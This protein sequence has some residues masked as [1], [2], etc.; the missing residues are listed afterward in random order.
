MNLWLWI[1][2]SSWRRLL[3][4]CFLPSRLIPNLAAGIILA[5]VVIG[6]LWYQTKID[7]GFIELTKKHISILILLIPLAVVL[8]SPLPFRGFGGLIRTVS[9]FVTLLVLMVT[10]FMDKQ[11]ACYVAFYRVIGVAINFMLFMIGL[12]SKNI[13]VTKTSFTMFMCCVLVNVILGIIGYSK[14]DAGLIQMA[15]FT[16]ALVDMFYAPF[17]FALLVLV[18]Q[19]HKWIYYMP[20]VIKKLGQK[21]KLRFPY[22]TSIMVGAVFALFFIS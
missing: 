2:E 7:K 21:E 5:F 11:R 10:G 18:S 8:V 16:F 9:I 20:M 14:G 3:Y 4:K 13:E 6:L 19:L 12:I 15:M 1:L 22:T 17:A